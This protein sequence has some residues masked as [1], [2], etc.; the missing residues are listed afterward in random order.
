MYVDTGRSDVAV[1]EAAGG[2]FISDRCLVV[3]EGYLPSLH[4]S[5]HGIVVVGNLGWA[6]RD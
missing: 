4:H 3:T 5:S 6:V 2:F 1:V